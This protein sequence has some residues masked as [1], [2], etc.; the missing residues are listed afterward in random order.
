MSIKR[1]PTGRGHRYTIDGRR[2]E[3]VT[4][5]I[6]K[7]I[8]KPALHHWYARTVAEYVADAVVYGDGRL[9]ALATLGRDGMVDAL[10]AIP[11]AQ[12]NA[13][14]VRGTEVHTLAERLSRGEVVEVPEHLAGYV[15]SCVRFLD[16]SRVAPLLTEATVGHRVRRYAGTFDMVGDLPD[17]R[18]A[19][20]DYKTGASGIWGETALQLAAYRHAEVY[21]TPEGAEASMD[22]LG[23]DTAYAVWLRPDGYDV[24]PVDAGADTFEEF[25]A[26]ARVARLVDGL[27]ERIGEAEDWAPAV[28]CA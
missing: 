20:F 6:N 13:A 5:L 15:E 22:A 28:M 18:R 12:T 8:P 21:V 14:A 26:V 2:V 27:R 16:E 24:L 10:S 7:G 11:R 23:I 3:G 25:L 17:G 9:D 1:I 4:T 19:I